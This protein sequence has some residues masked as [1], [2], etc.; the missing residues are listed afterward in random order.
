MSKSLTERFKSLKKGDLE[1]V[2][3][4][5]YRENADDYD[6]ND[7][8]DFYELYLFNT[9]FYSSLKPSERKWLQRMLNNKVPAILKLSSRTHS[10][11]EQ[12]SSI[13]RFVDEA[14]P[15]ERFAWLYD[16]VNNTCKEMI[17][18]GYICYMNT[19]ADNEM[20][21]IQHHIYL[22]KEADF[23]VIFPH[24]MTCVLDVEENALPFQIIFVKEATEEQ[25]GE[26]KTLT[27][28]KTT[29]GYNIS[30]IK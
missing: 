12:Y 11:V 23:D 25:E 16:Y 6:M 5:L 9:V 22:A 24:I 2:V 29:D 13:K 20:E 15:N 17:K 27:I 3:A 1:S 19:Y 7:I 26:R 10:I 14:I 28:R 21:N 30:E 8:K 4:F 18:K